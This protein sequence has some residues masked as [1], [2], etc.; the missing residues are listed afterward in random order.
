MGS[1]WYQLVVAAHDPPRL[2]RWWAEVLEYSVLY[3]SEQEV[4]IGLMADRYPGIVFVPVSDVKAT[5]N[6]LHIDLDP[7][8]HD[9]EVERIISLGATRVDVGRGDAPWTVL[10]DLEGNEFDILALHRSLIA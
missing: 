3:P 7:D 10:A 6:R 1:R 2:A 9:A 5:K 4:I 8:D